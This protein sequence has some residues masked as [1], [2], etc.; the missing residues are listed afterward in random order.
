MLFHLLTADEFYAVLDRL[1][2]PHDRK[3]IPRTVTYYLDRTS[4]GSTLSRVVHA[5][6]LARGNR[7]QAW[8]YF[9]E[10]LESDVDDVQG[11]T[12]GEGIHLGA[13]AGTLDLLQR[14]F[15][16]LQ[17]RDDALG[18]DPYLPEALTGMRFRL[19][20]RHHPEVEVAITHQTLT[21]GGGGPGLPLLPVRVRDDAYRIDPRGRLE[22]RLRRRRAERS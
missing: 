3:T 21:V 6:V 18:F 16:G 8:D 19:R 11:G 20:Y 7:A 4:H 12:T 14:G 17:T 1:G 13:M 2:Y 10:A 22:V 9:L 5:W 15:T